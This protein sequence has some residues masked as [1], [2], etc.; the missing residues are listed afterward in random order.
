MAD[1]KA[2]VVTKREIERMN[3]DN[4]DA[5]KRAKI[6]T[7]P[8]ETKKTEETEETEGVIAEVVATVLAEIVSTVVARIDK[9]DAQEEVIDL[10]NLVDDPEHYVLYLRCNSFFVKRS[11]LKHIFNEL[12]QTQHGNVITVDDDNEIFTSL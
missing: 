1:T 11:V 10:S 2:I 7:Q 3:G 9:A 5:N 12:I 4:D 8:T 6:G